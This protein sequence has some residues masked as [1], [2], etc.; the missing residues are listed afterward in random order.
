MLNF[1][2]IHFLFDVWKVTTYNRASVFLVKDRRLINKFTE[3]LVFLL[4]RIYLSLSLALIYKL[5]LINF[6]KILPWLKSSNKFNYFFFNPFKFTL[7][8]EKVIV[9]HKISWQRSKRLRIKTRLVNYENIYLVLIPV[10]NRYQDRNVNTF[11]L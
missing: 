6:F 4:I 1:K 11:N 10:F 8:P 2:L 3:W 7:K 5:S 9:G